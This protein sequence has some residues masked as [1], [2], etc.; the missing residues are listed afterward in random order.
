MRKTQKYICNIKTGNGII[1]PML[2]NQ[3]WHAHIANNDDMTNINVQW[4]V[5]IK[6]VFAPSLSCPSARPLMKL[7]QFSKYH[8]PQCHIPKVRTRGRT[9]SNLRYFLELSIITGP[10]PVYQE[11]KTHLLSIKSQF[12]QIRLKGCQIYYCC[13]CH[14]RNGWKTSWD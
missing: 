13:C 12:H 10:L 7:V 14:N 11:S 8:L 9:Y 2:K 1:V 3:L 4:S 5:G 6:A